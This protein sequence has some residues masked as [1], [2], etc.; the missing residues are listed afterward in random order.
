MLLKS[1]CGAA[2]E[3]GRAC[4]AAEGQ[5][6]QVGHRFGALVALGLHQ[7]GGLLFQLV[8]VVD[9]GTATPTITQLFSQVVLILA[10]SGRVRTRCG[11]LFLGNGGN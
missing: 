6:L 10:P 5:V 7:G 8:M 11:L 2:V 3:A 1:R 4:L 9:T